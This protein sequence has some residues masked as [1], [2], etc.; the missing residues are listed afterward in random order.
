[1]AGVRVVFTAVDRICRATAD[2]L[3]LS[4]LKQ[5]HIC[6]VCVQKR[7]LIACYGHSWN[8]NKEKNIFN[9]FR[10]TEKNS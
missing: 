5:A 9:C 6:S 3:N 1:M 10:T 4:L 8:E 7:A 2:S